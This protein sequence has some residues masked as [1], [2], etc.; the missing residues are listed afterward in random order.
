MR[1]IGWLL[2][3]A[4]IIAIF[5][6][7]APL[8][9]GEIYYLKPTGPPTPPAPMPAPEHRTVAVITLAKTSPTKAASDGRILVN[10]KEY[11]ASVFGGGTRQVIEFSGNGSLRAMDQLTTFSFG[12]THL[13]VPSAERGITSRPMALNLVIQNGST[14]GLQIDWSA[15]NLVLDGRALPVI[16]KGIRMVDRGLALAPSTVPPSAALDDFVYPKDRLT[17]GSSSW[18]GENFFESMRPGQTFTLYLPVKRGVETTE[19]QF[20]FAIREPDVP[21]EKPSAR[22]APSAPSPDWCPPPQQYRDGVCWPKS[23]QPSQ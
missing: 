13:D 4:T 15:T 14:T 12:M 3:T 7:C 5:A 16:H 1:R 2:L 17:F 19:Y 11:Y 6:G 23:A 18:F 20:T 10:R 8:R 22:T 9:Q 21:H